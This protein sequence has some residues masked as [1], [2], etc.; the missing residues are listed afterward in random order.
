M[1]RMKLERAADTLRELI[2][3]EPWCIGVRALSA[4][5]T[6]IDRPSSVSKIGVYYKRGQLGAAQ[7]NTPTVWK[8]W[9]VW[10]YEE[11]A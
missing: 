7:E 6:P 11:R 10:L 3:D 9:P 2:G 4:W 1:N 8:M 5:T